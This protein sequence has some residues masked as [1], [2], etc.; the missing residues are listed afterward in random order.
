M[1]RFWLLLFLTLCLV[2]SADSDNLKYGIPQETDVILDRT[3]FALGYSAS[4]RQALWVS[5]ILTAEEV[6]SK[7]A[8]RQSHFKTDIGVVCLRPSQ[9]VVTNSEQY[10]PDD[11]GRLVRV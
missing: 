9:L 7:E 6:E 3:G 1:K 11:I 5:Y 4:H 2:T 8:K 10:S